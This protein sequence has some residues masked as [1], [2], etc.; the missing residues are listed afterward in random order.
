MILAL[1]LKYLTVR[2][3]TIFAAGSDCKE[4]LN[5]QNYK[6]RRLPEVLKPP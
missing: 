1:T 6:K 5:L 2:K 3:A 4:L